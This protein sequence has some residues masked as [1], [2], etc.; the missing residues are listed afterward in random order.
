[1]NESIGESPTPPEQEVADEIVVKNPL[2][3]T[4][5]ERRTRLTGI[6]AES[7]V[8][9]KKPNPRTPTEDKPSSRNAE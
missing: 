6:L 1:M 7:G 5:P 2:P 3:S 9:L 4:D 8:V